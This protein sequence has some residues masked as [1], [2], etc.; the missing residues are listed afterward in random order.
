M[1]EYAGKLCLAPMVRSGELPMRLMALKYG[2]DLVWSPEIIDRKIRTCT[3]VENNELGTVDFV[4]TGK[5]GQKNSLIFRTNRRIE[6]GKLIFQLGSADPN[7]AVDG[8]LKVVNDVDGIDLNCGCPKPFSTHAGMGAALL[9]NADLLTLILTNL[10]EKVGK[11]YNKPISC[12]I[13]LLDPS[14]PQP[15]LELVEKICATG[16]ANLTVHCRTRDMRNRQVP[17][18]EYVHKI[19]EVTSKHGVSL[20]VNGGFLCK[21]EIVQ[22]QKSMGNDQIGGMMAEAAELNPTVFSDSPLPWK[23]VLPEFIRTCIS[24]K[25]HPSNTKYILL[26]QVP[27]KSKFYQMF[28]KVKSN[29]EFL[30]IAKQIGEDG[31]K[32]FIR[33]MQKDRLYDA[34]EFDGLFTKKRQLTDG[35]SPDKKQKLEFS[36]ISISTIKKDAIQHPLEPQKPLHASATI[37][38]TL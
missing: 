22:F 9:S 18:R 19:F 8:A 27:G 28:C 36:G 10:V 11:P 7:I 23:D 6:K 1:P 20:V 12:K 3:R 34:E 13:R 26:N 33:I 37:Q 14:D 38:Q 5:S 16:I 31:D 15:T 32:V 2:A 29:E 17:I 30:E 21:K 24:V 4:E 25:N 35:D